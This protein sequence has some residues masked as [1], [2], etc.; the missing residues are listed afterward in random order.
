VLGHRLTPESLWQLERERERGERNTRFLMIDCWFGKLGTP[1]CAIPAL[2]CIMRGCTINSLPDTTQVHVTSS[3]FFPFQFFFLI[4]PSV[5][6]RVYVQASPHESSWSIP[7]LFT[8]PPLPPSS[9]PLKKKR[10]P[11]AC[12]TATPYITLPG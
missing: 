1:T 6:A 7:C 9:N 11:K 12:A 4:F 8:G 10:R 2:A 3:I 5:S